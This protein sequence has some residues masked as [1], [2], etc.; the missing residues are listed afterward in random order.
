MERRVQTLELTLEFMLK[1]AT[2]GQPGRTA[3]LHFPQ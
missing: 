3:E 2:M 1:S